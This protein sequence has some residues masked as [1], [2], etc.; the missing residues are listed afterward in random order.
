MNIKVSSLLAATVVALGLASTASAIVLPS[1]S[2]G[3]SDVTAGGFACTIGTE[4]FSNFTVSTTGQ[5]MPTIVGLAT[6]GTGMF[7][8]DADLE[9]Q[10]SAVFTSPSDIGDLLINYEVTGGLYGVDAV[11]QGV[12]TGTVS[13]LETVCSVAFVG[14]AC[15]V[16]ATTYSMTVTSTNGATATN[17]IQ[18][19]DLGTAFIKKDISFN[20]AST[21]E[22]QNSQLVPEP[23][24]FSLMGAGL[25]GLGLLGRRLRK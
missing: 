8:S 23:M 10:F 6:A 3:T 24:T 2:A 18:F 7:G 22:I 20:G 12:G 5:L 1:C 13:M 14:P 16:G 15:P 9:F 25:L 11:I 17:A 21:S 4:T 19:A